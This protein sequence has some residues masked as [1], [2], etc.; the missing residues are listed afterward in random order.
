MTPRFNTWFSWL[1]KWEGTV[2]ENDPNDAGGATKYGI[3]QRSHPK[4]DIRAL[5]EERAASLYW[6][7]AWTLMH[8]EEL[9]PG[10]GEV[11]ANI[12]VNCGAHAAV[13]WMQTILGLK[14]D[15][16]YGPITL[17]AATQAVPSTLCYK[18]LSRTEQHYRSIAKGRKARY[19]KG[20]LN[21]NNSLNAFIQP[22]LA[23]D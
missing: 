13:T 20:W 19:L 8:A 22:L 15:G 21:R 10:V 1:L 9:H 11:L 23:I 17:R 16:F 4:V 18:L 14:V 6:N 7:E 2:Y 12:A 3:D 5:T